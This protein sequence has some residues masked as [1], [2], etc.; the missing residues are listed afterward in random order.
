MRP[1]RRVTPSATA[2][3]A[4]KEPLAAEA[5]TAGRRGHPVEAGRRPVQDHPRRVAH[6]PRHR[7]QDRRAAVEALLQGARGV[8][9][10]PRA[11]T[12][13]TSTGSG[14]ARRPARR[15]WSPRPRSWPIRGLGTDRRPVPGP[16]GRVEG[17]RP[18]PEG[19]RR[20]ALAAVPRRPG[21]LLRPAQRLL[22]R[23][24]RGVRGQRRGQE[25]AARRGREDQHLRSGGGPG[26][27]AAIQERWEEIGKVPRD[28]IR[29]LEA[30]LRAVEERVRSPPSSTGGAPT[31]RPTPG[32]PSSGTGSPSSRPRRPRPGRPAT[33]AAPSRPSSR[34]SSGGSG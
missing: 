20:H 34:P 28:D 5:E 2:A 9:P 12:S 16:D 27:V 13:P 31:R 32:S 19:R 17:R 8:Q 18:R 26:R 7:P 11:R 1:A 30:R 33:P 22:L 23:A 14:P 4:R 25:G 3:I 21:R 29:P 10:P 6:H 15:S 24:G